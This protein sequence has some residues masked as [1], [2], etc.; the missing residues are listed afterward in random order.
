MFVLELVFFCC[1]QD[2]GQYLVVVDDSN[3][4]TMSLWD[5]GRDQSPHKVTE[6]KVEWHLFDK[7]FCN[8]YI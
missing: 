5:V 1:S 7:T 6:T 4:H 8:F 3:E 2:S